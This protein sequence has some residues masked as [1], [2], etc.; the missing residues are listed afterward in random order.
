MKDRLFILM[1]AVDLTVVTVM[2]VL[3]IHT[4]WPQ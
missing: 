1:A 4:N 2:T 3:A